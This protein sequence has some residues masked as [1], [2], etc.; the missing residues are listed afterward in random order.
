MNYPIGFLVAVLLLFGV[1]TS[2]SAETTPAD[3]GEGLPALSLPP[4]PP[5]SQFNEILERPLFSPSRRPAA[6]DNAMLGMATAEELR[7]QWK[8]TGIMLVGS[9]FKAMLRQRNGDQH[10]ILGTGMP[11]DDTWVLTEIHGNDILLEAG[12]VQ[13]LMQ[14]REPRDTEPREVPANE[15]TEAKDEG[16]DGAASQPD[17]PQPKEVSNE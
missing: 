10:R 14:L 7:E 4:F 5:L 15:R 8:L 3:S 16:A 11:L 9:E 13:V 12:D 6:D 2:A 1:H 17:E